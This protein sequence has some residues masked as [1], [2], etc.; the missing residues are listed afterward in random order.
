MNCL[1]FKEIKETVSPF[2][3]NL[4]KMLCR[5]DCFMDVWLCM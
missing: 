1:Y 5:H 3:D 2:M 4:R